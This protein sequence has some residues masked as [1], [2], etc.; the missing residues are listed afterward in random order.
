MF[1]LITGDTIQGE[2]N[3][4]TFFVGENDQKVVWMLY[5]DDLTWLKSPAAALTLSRAQE[6]SSYNPDKTHVVISPA[7]F[8]STN[9]LNSNNLSVEYVPL[10]YTLFTVR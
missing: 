10:P 3:P 2:S 5:R 9:L 1:N 4:E 8:A 7:K 6:L